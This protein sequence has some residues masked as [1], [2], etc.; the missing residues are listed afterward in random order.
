MLAHVQGR[1]GNL[2]ARTQ[3][4]SLRI[5]GALDRVSGSVN[6]WPPFVSLCPSR[7][8]LSAVLTRLA[9]FALEPHVVAGPWKLWGPFGYGCR[10][11]R[12]FTAIGKGLPLCLLGCN[13]MGL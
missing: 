4:Q 10:I 13:T 2:L 12:P 1:E 8:L 7:Y 5:L 9:G 11:S 6:C 3:I